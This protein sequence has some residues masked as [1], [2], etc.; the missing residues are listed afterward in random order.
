[1]WSKNNVAL[2]YSGRHAKAELKSWC[3]L[4]CIQSHDSKLVSKGS[5]CWSSHKWIY[6]G[7]RL[8]SWR[9]WVIFISFG[10]PGM[11]NCIIS[12]DHWGSGRSFGLILNLAG[13]R[14]WLF[15]LYCTPFGEWQDNWSSCQ[16]S[17]IHTVTGHS[18]L[19]KVAGQKMPACYFWVVFTVQYSQRELETTSGSYCTYPSEQLGWKSCCGEVEGQKG[20]Q[21][22]EPHLPKQSN[23]VNS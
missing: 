2:L 18:R 8:R 23:G 16:F 3:S 22:G 4:L 13:K 1:M 21:L 12:V 14:W 20:C 19:P 15:W 5:S 10:A 7:N 17:G 11:L 9:T 6:T